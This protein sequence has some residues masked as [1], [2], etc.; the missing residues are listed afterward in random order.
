MQTTKIEAGFV[1]LILIDCTL[2]RVNLRRRRI[3]LFLP[4]DLLE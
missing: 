4:V 3:L 1:E 2:S